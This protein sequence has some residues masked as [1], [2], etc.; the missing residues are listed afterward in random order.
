MASAKF[1][2]DK[3]DIADVYRD[4]TLQAVVKIEVTAQRL[5]VAVKSQ[6]YQASG[7]GCR[8]PVSQNCRR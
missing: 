4:T 2:Y 1:V 5:P 3:E 8:V 6:A 7:P